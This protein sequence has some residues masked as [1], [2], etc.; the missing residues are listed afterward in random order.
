M[1][2]DAINAEQMN[3]GFVDLAAPAAAVPVARLVRPTAAIF[4]Q[5]LSLVAN[6][7]ELREDRAAE[8]LAQASGQ[9]IE[10][11]EFVARRIGHDLARTRYE[12]DRSA[13][14]ATERDAVAFAR[15]NR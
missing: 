3:V 1:A 12:V 9:A 14:R 4:Q 13:R 11:E 8:I 6:Y 15:S 7:A 2:Q 5:Q 10:G